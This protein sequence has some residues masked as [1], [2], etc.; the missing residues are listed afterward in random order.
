MK[1]V[2]S[3]I[4]L[5]ITLFSCQKEA[6]DCN[7]GTTRWDG[8]FVEVELNLRVTDMQGKS[9]SKLRT[10]A[11]TNNPYSDEIKNVWFLQLEEDGTIFH[12]VYVADYNIKTNR[13]VVNIP[14]CNGTFRFVYI[15]NSFNSTLCEGANNLTELLALSKPMESEMGCFGSE[16]E[17]GTTH[18]YSTMSGDTTHLFN[19]T[20]PYL[21]VCP[22]YRNFAWV[23]VVITEESSKLDYYSGQLCGVQ[24]KSYY[25][26]SLDEMESSDQLSAPSTATYNFPI[27]KFPN[28]WE[29]TDGKAEFTY[30][31]PVNRRGQTTNE[32]EKK[33]P[34]NAPEGS[35]YFSMSLIADAPRQGSLYPT[36]EHRSVYQYKYY[37]G[38]N[39]SNDFN[40]LANH[41]YIT[42]IKFKSPG[43][44]NH[45]K[46]ISLT[47]VIEMPRGDEELS[48]CYII[49]PDPTVKESQMYAIPIKERIVDFWT[50]YS[51]VT[52]EATNIN[53]MFESGAWEVIP[54]W[55]DCAN[56][57]F[58][59]QLNKN[60]ISIGK[61][62]AYGDDV[63]EHI[64]IM[65]KPEF[66]NYGNLVVAVRDTRNGSNE[67]LWS[68]HLWLTDYNP[69]Y[70][71]DRQSK[72]EGDAA[73][74]NKAYFE[75]VI[76]GQ[77]HH[78]RDATSGGSVWGTDG[79]YETTLIMDRN[80]GAMGPGGLGYGTNLQGRGALYYQFGRKDPFPGSVAH[81]LNGGSGAEGGP[82]FPYAPAPA[83]IHNSVNA[84]TTYYYDG[85]AN[86]TNK[87]SDATYLWNDKECTSTSQ[88][89]KSIF[90]PSPFL[91]MLPDRNVWARLVQDNGSRF[92]NGGGGRY[93]DED[94]LS[95]YYPFGGFRSGGS[96]QNTGSN[97]NLRQG[98][99]SSYMW[100]A[101]ASSTTN[102]YRFYLHTTDVTQYNNNGRT[103]G[104]SVRCVQ[105]HLQ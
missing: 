72:P 91:F 10:S 63:A 36:V 83:A 53:E 92:K 2:L 100:N 18:Y 78:Y 95:A 90:D 9:T 56:D 59:A 48:N 44:H 25:L 14:A 3:Y 49:N 34:D 84:P 75:Q 70:T 32:D 52:K 12:R 96:N 87:Q 35:T 47:H 11:T 80:I 76:N 21:E 26:A 73:L 79:A 60:K 101:A 66:N 4:C 27:V 30:Y 94:E 97:A 23:S 64:Y 99:T 86:W 54:L 28:D 104:Q 8:D 103:T 1:R 31:V 65:T 13:H 69:Y 58:S 88:K 71:P 43:H 46:R 85:G 20:D 6:F 19:T 50:N 16:E 67:I 15:V 74:A 102:G 89:K 57:P 39:T 37:L 24:N 42:N 77:L 7:G 55:Y 5:V 82:Y 38:A 29:T 33:K 68:W 45:D 62:N 93:Y 81:Y 51:S 41:W 105:Q 61:Y 22:V 98:N 40:L 17:G